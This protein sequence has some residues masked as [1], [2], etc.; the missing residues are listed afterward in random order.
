MN[1]FL[2][3]LR[4][5]C[6]PS[7]HSGQ[8]WSEKAI[9]I[10]SVLS[11]EGMDL[12]DE[13]VYLLFTHEPHEMLEGKGQ[14][15]IARPVIG[16][17][18]VL[19]APFSLVDWVAAPV[20]RETVQGETFEDILRITEDSRLKA[21]KENP[22]LAPGFFLCVQRRLVPELKLRVEVIFYQ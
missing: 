21:L 3:N 10:D 14:C 2:P 15:L 22:G 8:D 18:K 1:S 11:E 13:S 20:W 5:L 12:S 19:D 4:W 6:L 7:T 9:E 17:K 16:P